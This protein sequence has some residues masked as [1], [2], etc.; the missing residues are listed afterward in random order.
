MC[1]LKLRFLQ[2]INVN[3]PI[4]DNACFIRL[5]IQHYK[6][7]GFTKKRFICVNS[8]PIKNLQSI[9]IKQIIAFNC[10]LKPVNC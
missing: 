10:R 4:Y 6:P 7:H 5:N 8:Q 9:K 2:Q 1:D 3:I